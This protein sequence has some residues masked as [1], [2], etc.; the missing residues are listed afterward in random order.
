VEIHQGTS[1]EN[2]FPIFYGQRI[3]GP[4]FIYSDG[5]SSVEAK[6]LRI[7]VV[8][9]VSTSGDGAYG[10]GWFRITRE[11]RIE[12]LAADPT[13]PVVNEQGYDLTDYENMAQPTYEGVYR[14]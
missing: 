7:G 9:Q 3:K 12:N 4:P 11:G 10:S 6:P 2:L 5:P 14:P 8:Y 1:C 13:P